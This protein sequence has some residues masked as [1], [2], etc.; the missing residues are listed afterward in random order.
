MSNGSLDYSKLKDR[1]LLLILVGK[2]DDLHGLPRR[3]AALERKWAWLTGIGSA[4]GSAL[5]FLE[6]R[7]HG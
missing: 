1:E 7:R 2:V 6:A 4:V 5:A 3:V